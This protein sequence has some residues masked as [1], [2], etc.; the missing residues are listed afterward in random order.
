MC[1][2]TYIKR[3]RQGK[4]WRHYLLQLTSSSVLSGHSL[5][6]WKLLILSNSV[7]SVPFTGTNAKHGLRCKACKMSIHHKCADSIG[8]QRCM[9]KLVSE[10]LKAASAARSINFACWCQFPCVPDPLAAI[11]LVRWQD[12]HQVASLRGEK[13]SQ[14]LPYSQF[15]QLLLLKN[16]NKN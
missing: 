14:V 10:R 5:N 9:G 7:I 4:E 13:P 6:A 2:Q 12:S 3:R 1:A 15:G 8:Q 16:L 11:E